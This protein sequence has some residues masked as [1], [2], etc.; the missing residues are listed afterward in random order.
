MKLESDGWILKDDGTFEADISIQGIGQIDKGF[1]EIDEEDW[2]QQMAALN[3]QAVS[4]MDGQIINIS[5]GSTVLE[6]EVASTP[7]S[8]RRGLGDRTELPADG[9]LFVYAEDHDARFSRDPM[10]FDIVI[11]FFDAEGRLFDFDRTSSIIKAAS[12]YRYVLETD[13]V[14]DLHGDLTLTS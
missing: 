3:H 9:M 2:Q 4:G 6:V 1:E 10:S 5:V 13:P 11:W 8:Y 12:P 14:L 7:A